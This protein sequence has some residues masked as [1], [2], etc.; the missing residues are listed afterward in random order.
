M[1]EISTQVVKA[2]IYRR[3]AEVIRAGRAELAAGVQTLR[4]LGVTAGTDADTVRI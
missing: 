2:G 3:G 1:T 4:V